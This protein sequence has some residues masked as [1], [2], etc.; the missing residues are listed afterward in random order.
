VAR[1]VVEA[2][3]D[4]EPETIAKGGELGG[5]NGRQALAKKGKKARAVAEAAEVPPA[6]SKLLLAAVTPQSLLETPGRRGSATRRRARRTISG[7]RS[8]LA[9]TEVGG[10]ILTTEVT[11]MEGRWRA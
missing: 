11:V 5:G 2:S 4:D 1:K 6:E 10:S 7:P 9:W 8:D 3:V